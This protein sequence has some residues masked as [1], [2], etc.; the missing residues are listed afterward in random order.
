MKT[1][2]LEIALKPS[3]QFLYDRFRAAGYE[4]YIV[5]GF[6]RD[7][8]LNRPGGDIDFATS[9]RPAEMIRLFE[10]VVRTGIKYGTCTI[11]IGTDSYEVTTYRTEGRYEDRRRPSK[12]DFGTD[13]LA[14]LERRDFTI[15]AFAYDIAR[16]EVIDAFLGQEDLHSKCIRTIGNAEDRFNEDALRMMRAARLVGELNFSLDIECLLGMKACA[17]QLS[18]VSAERLRDE[19]SK[20]LLSDHPVAGLR[21]LE[22]G[23]LLSYL[24][25]ELVKTQGVMQN[26]F[27]AHD[28]YE[29]TLAVVDA[30]AKYKRTLATKDILKNNITLLLAALLHDIGKPQTRKEGE[31]EGQVSFLNHE[32]EGAKMSQVILKRLK[33]SKRD[34]ET[35]VLL[36]R[37]HMIYNTS[38]WSD[39]GVRRWLNRVGIENK[40][41]LIALVRADRVGRGVT[42]RM[43]EVA[44]EKENA[45]LEHF[46]R[47][48]DDLIAS[49]TAF[50]ISDLKIGGTEL[51]EVFSLSPSPLIG[52]VLQHLLE[53]VL[54][55][56]ALNTDKKLLAEAEIFLKSKVF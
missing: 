17:K 50:K 3:V 46:E 2:P 51:M 6:V 42:E 21:A 44:R 10:R 7:R 38:K 43:T 54:E 31:L 5:G 4:L 35:V 28:V 18:Q 20:L 45:D 40:D 55:D 34:I 52:E 33:F 26:A 24:L 37:E 22:K 9:A 30:V 14:D 36:V 25:P 27:H 48:I 41:R 39:G 32:Q 8:L 12:V 11:L 15:N 1:F 29:H 19:L 23:T 56:P 16:G 13:L 47:R 53:K 49:Q